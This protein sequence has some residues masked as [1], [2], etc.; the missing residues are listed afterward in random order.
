MFV[1]VWYIESVGVG[2]QIPTVVVYR[3]YWVYIC[4]TAGGDEGLL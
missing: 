2:V 3:N 4:G 1:N